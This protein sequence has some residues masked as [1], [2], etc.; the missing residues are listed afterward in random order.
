MITVLIIVTL[1]MAVIAGLLYFFKPR[2]KPKDGVEKSGD[3]KFKIPQFAKDWWK[4]IDK[5][6][7]PGQRFVL[8][9]VALL[10]AYIEFSI[11]GSVWVSLIMLLIAAIIKPPKSKVTLAFVWLDLIVLITAAFLPGFAT[12]RHTSY[13]IAKT[14]SLK[15]SEKMDKYHKELEAGNP[16]PSQASQQPPATY[17]PETRKIEVLV[18]EDEYTEVK[19]PS[20]VQ[21][22]IDCPDDGLAKVFHRDAQQGISYDCAQGPIEVGE[23]LHNFRIGFSAK[24]EVPVKVVVRITS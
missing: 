5:E 7:S 13:E 1:V 18:T 14:W 24:T 8:L 23:N 20:G 6:S 12:M 2:P 11:R 17:Q 9:V 15:Q 10:V 3:N 21:F 4:N 22:S 19:I 16:S